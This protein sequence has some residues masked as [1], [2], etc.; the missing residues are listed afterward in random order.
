MPWTWKFEKTWNFKNEIIAAVALFLNIW[1]SHPN[2]AVFHMLFSVFLLNLCTAREIQP[3]E[4]GEYFIKKYFFLF[5]LYFWLKN[6]R[7]IN[8]DSFNFLWLGDWGGWPAPVYNTPIQAPW[9]KFLWWTEFC[10]NIKSHAGGWSL[11]SRKAVKSI[12]WETI[13]L[14]RPHI[15]RY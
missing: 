8:G 4:N 9:T 12:F 13:S 7:T 14:N 11:W 5:L 6:F 1:F 10:P 2:S 15:L 3:D